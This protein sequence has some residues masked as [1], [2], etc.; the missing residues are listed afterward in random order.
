MNR[1]EN[2]SSDSSCVRGVCTLRMAAVPLKVSDNSGADA[3]R[4]ICGNATV[5]DA[6]Y[7][8]D[9]AL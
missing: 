3:G 9:L 6:L 5:V 4:P 1:Y 7:G 8:K 2:F